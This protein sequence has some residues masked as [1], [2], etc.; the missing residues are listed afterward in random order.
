MVRKK[1][2]RRIAGIL[3]AILVAGIAFF[4][5]PFSNYPVSL[6]VMKVYSGM[7]EKESIMAEKG[8]TLEIPGGGITKE[9]DWYPFVMTFNDS[10]GFRRFLAEQ[11]APAGRADYSELELTILYNFPAFDLFAGCSRLYDTT[12][13]YYNG[14]Y[15]AYLVSGDVV[16]ADGS[17][18]PYG[19]TPEGSLD[20]AATAQVPQFDFQKLVL[21]DMGID[22]SQ[23]VFDWTLTGTEE[24]VDF[25]GSDGWTR[26]DA[27]L[28]VN[29]V[30]HT[31]KEFHQSYLQYGPP[32]F[33][34]DADDLEAAGTGA[35][36]HEGVVGSVGGDF[37]PV[38]LS[39]RLYGKYLPEYDTSLFFYVLAKDPD[40]VETC[41][42][43]ILERS[44][45][46]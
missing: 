26:A 10:A 42:K 45:V 8:I 37:A 13:P 1:H 28:M 5:S 19:F 29:G 38:Y 9:K 27:V 44:R 6:A 41:S 31:K 33:K 30:S 16:E 32:G 17:R 22:R 24:G 11:P 15:G 7:H 18:H 23:L 46:E 35:A 2:F 36:G 43:E 21:G 25:A 14:F 4:W 20:T 39:G 34:K 12:S 40:V 3:A